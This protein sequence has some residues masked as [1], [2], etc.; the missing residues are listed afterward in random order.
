ML[1]AWLHDDVFA[2]N[3]DGREK[4]IEIARAFLARH[5]QPESLADGVAGCLKAL[6]EDEPGGHLARD[7][8]H[9]A[10]LAPLASSVFSD[11]TRNQ[12]RLLSIADRRTATMIHVNAIMISLVVGLMLRKLEEHSALFAPTVL[13]ICVNLA[14]IVVSI[15]SMRGG[16][17]KLRQIPHE[18]MV[19]HDANLLLTTNEV[20]VSLHEYLERMGELTAEPPALQKA[21]LEYVYFAR[22]LLI[23]RRKMLQLT[24]N[25]FIYGLAVSVLLFVIA[26]VRS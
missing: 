20:N 25:I 13:L 7:V 1:S 4:S 17:W 18:E 16:R 5:G 2:V 11:L 21:M 22:K 9:D 19:T 6:D 23:G 24:Y 10:L 14:V 3:G 12:L 26:I 8:L 15:L